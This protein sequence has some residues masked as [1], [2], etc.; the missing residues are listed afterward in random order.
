MLPIA[1]DKGSSNAEQID[2]V[3]YNRTNNNATTRAR[4][5][6]SWLFSIFGTEKSMLDTPTPVTE[7][8]PDGLNVLATLLQKIQTLEGKVQAYEE[9]LNNLTLNIPDATL[10]AIIARTLDMHAQV[11][12][13]AT[14]PAQTKPQETEPLVEV[15]K[16]T[17]TTA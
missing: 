8:R 3:C 2:S 1:K 16:E 7:H 17:E 13:A 5:P 10:N 6:F 15:L 12:M 9:R 4:E 14:R 11:L